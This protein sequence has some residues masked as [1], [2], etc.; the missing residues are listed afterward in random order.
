M[1]E[2]EKGAA[3]EM[4]AIPGNSILSD[5]HPT[6]SDNEIADNLHTASKPQEGVEEEELD[7]F[8]LPIPKIIINSRPPS[9]DSESFTSARSSIIHDAQHDD[10][11]ADIEDNDVEDNTEPSNPSM[12]WPRLSRSTL[13]GAGHVK[14]SPFHA[15]PSKP[16]EKQTMYADRAK[17]LVKVSPVSNSI[18]KR[19]NS[20]IE[21]TFSRSTSLSAIPTQS[22]PGQNPPKEIRSQSQPPEETSRV[23]NIENT[24][25][26]TNPESTTEVK[27][28]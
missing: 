24:S 25:E 26:I 17:E 4:S 19:Q 28:K 20:P 16:P 10:D 9:S 21:G 22:E 11:N 15:G 6:D 14:S 5:R 8:G 7:D 23:T 13:P 3:S 1:T 2:K 18:F 27:P 12:E